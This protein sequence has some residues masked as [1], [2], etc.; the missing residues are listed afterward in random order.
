MAAAAGGPY[1][2]R[3]W[4]GPFLTIMTLSAICCSAAITESYA[5][6]ATAWSGWESLYGIC[7]RQPWWFLALCLCVPAIAEWTRG[8]LRNPLITAVAKQLLNAFQA[9]VFEE[10]RGDD[11]REHLHRVTL[12][13]HIEWFWPRP[14]L[15]RDVRTRKL[16]FSCPGPHRGWMVP[17]ARSGVTCQRTAAAFRAPDNANNAEGVAG[18]VWSGMTD[19][20]QQDLP[21]ITTASDQAAIESYAKETKVQPEW[22]HERLSMGLPLANAYYAI[23]VSVREQPWGVI[24][25][26][27]TGG[28][29][30]TDRIE[31]LA[32]PLR[33]ILST[34]L[35]EM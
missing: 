30:P 14:R 8:R 24:V 22:V 32:R 15:W 7:R 3:K 28:K 21:T 4:V 23:R 27:S 13:R 25:I 31:Q 33:R 26:D 35:E 16:K 34:V 5:T 20:F 19:W 11:L 2:M 6:P 1:L 29:L 10:I 9:E 17:M 12:F 18:F